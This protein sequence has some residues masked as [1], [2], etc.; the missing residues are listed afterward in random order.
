[1]RGA[2]GA[3]AFQGGGLPPLVSRRGVV[4]VAPPPP[5][6]SRSPLGAYYDAAQLDGWLGR[7]LSCKSFYADSN[8]YGSY[9]YEPTNSSRDPSWQSRSIIM[10]NGPYAPSGN[11]SNATER[12]RARANGSMDSSIQ[13]AALSLA[14]VLANNSN[15]KTVV[16]VENEF[17]CSWNVLY[18]SED[19]A[20][21]KAGVQ[22]S[23]SIC[24]AILGS[25][26]IYS[27]CPSHNWPA[28]MNNASAPTAWTDWYVGDAYCDGVGMTLYSTT[29]PSSSTKTTY[30]STVEE[31]LMDS[32]NDW[33]PEAMFN[34]A[35]N[36]GKRFVISEYG[37]MWDISP[38]GY[39]PPSS[40]DQEQAN[41]FQYSFDR[42]LNKS[43]TALTVFFNEWSSDGYH[44][45]DNL[46]IARAKFI[47]LWS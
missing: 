18:G 9:G 27:L 24:K 47:E 25:S 6:T 44:K 17:Q 13:S 16:L 22:R 33:G 40:Y 7:K 39:Y 23:Y 19:V 2:I 34:F 10:V 14:N 21:W 1:M 41:F 3:F 36:H 8:Q 4:P 32:R 28:N 20:A 12:N 31:Q 38:W 45:L 26:L 5:S 42:W 35:A 43:T 15:Y 37:P 29:R 46:P 11:Y 30:G